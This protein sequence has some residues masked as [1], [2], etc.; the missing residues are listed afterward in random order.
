ML[1]KT[2]KEKESDLKE[3]QEKCQ[4]TKQNLIALQ[5]SASMF[6]K[7]VYIGITSVVLKMLYYFC[8]RTT[9]GN[10]SNL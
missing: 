6:N 5:E 9:T 2:L 7:T 8:I 1:N 3:L 4:V 10:I